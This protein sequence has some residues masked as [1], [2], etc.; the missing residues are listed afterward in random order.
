MLFKFHLIW[1]YS[2]PTYYMHDALLTCANS[3]HTQ[4]LWG[5]FK[6]ISRK[7]FDSLSE[8]LNAY[9]INPGE[10]WQKSVSSSFWCCITSHSVK[11]QSSQ[12]HHVIDC[13][14]KSHETIS[15]CWRWN[16]DYINRQYDVI[17]CLL[18]GNLMNLNL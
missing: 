8:G 9:N 6:K 11:Q 3:Q 16:P 14:R 2:N 4:G 12:G 17:M 7:G 18:T 10:V 1:M 15:R 13:L 5:K